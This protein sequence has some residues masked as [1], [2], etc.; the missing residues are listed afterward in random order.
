MAE[1]LRGVVLYP[2]KGLP[3]TQRY[4]CETFQDY[5]EYI[6]EE[7]SKLQIKIFLYD[8]AMYLP[9]RRIMTARMSEKICQ[10]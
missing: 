9:D 4:M 2:R 3:D 10:L 5:I 8:E 6:V 7:A 1:L